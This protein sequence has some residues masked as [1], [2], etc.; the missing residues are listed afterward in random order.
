MAALTLP[1][2]KAEG[3]S[4][5][6]GL[7]R[8]LGGRF[9][10]M[11]LQFATVITLARAIGPEGFGLAQ[12]AFVV[13]G[14]GIVLN[15]LG[16]T[17]LGTREGGRPTSRLGSPGRVIGGRILLSI[18]ILVAVGFA[19]IVLRRDSEAAAVIAIAVLAGAANL[20]WLLQ[21]DRAFGK[22]AGLEV[23]AAGLQLVGAVAV[24]LVGGNWIAGLSV[25]VGGPVI[26]AIASLGAAAQRHGSTLVPTVGAATIPLIRAA[27]PLGVALVVTS[28]Y[29][30]FDSLVLGLTRSPEE[31]G[32]YGGAYRIVLAALVLPV[33]V[34]GVALP[35]LAHVADSPTGA[36]RPLLLGLSVA[37]LSVAI[38]AAVATTLY[39]D[40]LI[41][42]IFGP[43]FSESAPLLRLLIWSLVTVSANVPFAVLL[44]AE[45][46]DRSYMAATVI[47]A[48]VS[49]GLG[50]ATVPTYGPTAAA[51]VTLISE[52]TVLSTIVWLTR[53]ISVPVLLRALS[54]ALLPTGGILIGM[55]ALP[56]AV[57][58]AAA[59]S[60]VG[61]LIAFGYQ[62]A[63]GVYRQ[64]FSALV[65]RT[66]VTTR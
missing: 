46:R 43:S 65:A 41:S 44:L 33:A 47:G 60:V 18:P 66:N 36:V 34:H 64:P 53:S 1:T 28:I 31:V 24:Y 3:P 16:L 4:I 14:Y 45:R 19:A 26:L 48:V 8:W 15:D 59:L 49:V 22:L 51:S 17:T 63:L 37:L 42:M 6:D 5:A 10:T 30:S 50:I 38:P 21:A 52:V 61:W 56:G 58:V 11:A 20:R 13:Y 25:L 35:L 40:P 62:Y 39:A 2:P 32:L 55:V 9:A 27:L 29:Y 23:A 54:L 7:K 57:H 12:F